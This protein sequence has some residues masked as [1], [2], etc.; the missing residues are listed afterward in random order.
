MDPDPAYRRR[1]PSGRRRAGWRRGGCAGAVGRGGVSVGDPSVSNSAG[2]P[3]FDTVTHLPASGAPG[4][5]QRPDL[6]GTD[7]GTLHFDVDTAALNA[8][9]I[10]WRSDKGIELADVWNREVNHFNTWF[11]L[12]PQ[13]DTALAGVGGSALNGLGIKPTDTTIL[14]R[15]ATIEDFGKLMGGDLGV[16]RLTWQPVDGLWAV[17]MVNAES[18]DAAMTAAQTLKLDRAQRCVTPMH[19]SS[20][21]NGYTW[22]GCDALFGPDLPW[23][24]GGATLTNPLA[25]ISG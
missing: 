9:G 4:A 2:P 1:R 16:W 18:V 19:L 24:L 14:G 7:P 12:S 21:P 11:G 8:S 23:E 3:R 10:S 22:T 6:V 13:K 17:V 20:L 5:A 25:S 15:P